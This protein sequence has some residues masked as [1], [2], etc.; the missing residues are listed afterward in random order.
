MAGTRAAMD[1]EELKRMAANRAAESITDGMALGLGTGSTVRYLLDHIQERRLAGDWL[2]IS[3]VPTS[4][5][6][7]QRARE[8]GI[9]I[10][11]LEQQPQVDLTVDGADEFDPELNLIKGLGGALL[12]EKIVASV[13]RRFVVMVDESKRVETL[14]SRGP[15]PV[16]VEPF[17]LGAVLP[18]LRALGSHP[19]LR[20]AASGEPFRTDGG[21]FV[22]HCHFDGGILDPRLLE[23]ELQAL[24]GVLETGLFLAMATEVVVAGGSGVEVLRA[25][26]SS[27]GAA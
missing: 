19:E 5:H 23:S 2:S 7:E 16:E 14:G 3:A 24:P 4:R 22:V 6:T 15:L 18:A 11:S 21:H 9:P 1:A 13:S 27:R 8:M 26:R 25:S 10:L 17:G 12:R 20:R